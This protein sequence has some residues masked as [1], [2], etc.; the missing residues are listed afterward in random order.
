[1]SQENRGSAGNEAE[2]KATKKMLRKFNTALTRKK[3]DEAAESDDLMRQLSFLKQ[4]NSSL[5]RENNMLK[6]QVQNDGDGDTNSPLGTSDSTDGINAEFE[7]SMRAVQQQSTHF[8]GMG[9]KLV[10]LQ[11]M[12]DQNQKLEMKIDDLNSTIAQLLNEKTMLQEKLQDPN[13]ERPPSPSAEGHS[14]TSSMA[15]SA[16][17][18]R[19]QALVEKLQEQI[20]RTQEEN[21]TVMEKFSTMSS[22][23][24]EEISRLNRELQHAKVKKEEME[25]QVKQLKQIVDKQITDDSSGKQSPQVT[26]M[27]FALENYEKRLKEMETKLKNEREKHDK[28]SYEMERKLISETRRLEKEKTVIKTELENETAGHSNTK[29]LLQEL[30]VAHEEAAQK[31]EE[32]NVVL[33]ARDQ[34]VMQDAAV[35]GNLKS[36]IKRLEGVVA[37][38]D[39]RNIEMFVGSV[40]VP[41]IVGRADR[42]IRNKQTADM[43]KKIDDQAREIDL[44]TQCKER[45]SGEMKELEDKMI[46]ARHKHRTEIQDMEQTMKIKLKKSSQLIKELQSQLAKRTENATY[47]PSPQA[48]DSGIELAIPTVAHHRRDSEFT[49]STGPS[50]PHSMSRSDG[51]LDPSSLNGSSSRRRTLSID[52]NSSTKPSYKTLELENEQLIEKSCEL[53]NQVW[54]LEQLVNRSQVDVSRIRDESQRKSQIIGTYVDQA[55]I[56]K[57]AHDAGPKGKLKSTFSKFTK[58]PP[59][60]KLGQGQQMKKMKHDM[61]HVVEGTLHRTLELEAENQKL[62]QQLQLLQGAQTAR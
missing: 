29:N 51:N 18:A 50:S 55:V 2:E 46:A 3:K 32:M 60:L 17:V 43:I 5:T 14:A 42:C 38:M 25:E 53:Q 59:G 23:E 4:Q 12:K 40:V 9:K 52:S 56:D 41:D 35:S 7:S 48:S 49:D 47:L 33:S 22:Q 13:A 31:M 10:A 11:E 45:H 19:L 26:H 15:E 34:I 20:K 6:T 30:R 28:A 21:A 24:M 62:K 16:E 27:K 39:S 54:K 36:E 58:V 8:G 1:M 57:V 37:Q 61:Q 44:L